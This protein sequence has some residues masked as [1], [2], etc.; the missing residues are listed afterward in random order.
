MIRLSLIAALGAAVASWLAWSAGGAVGG[1][2]L[3][4]YL[5][6][7]GL[8]GLGVLYQQHTLRTRPEFA[9]H[10]FTIAFFAKFVGMV[11][12]ALAFRYVPA[13]AARAD[14]RSFLVAFAV[15]ALLLL[16]SG[17]LDLLAL[18]KRSGR[19]LRSPRSL[20]PRS[21]EKGRTV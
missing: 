1:G 20:E 10:A 16:F 19:G 12:G 18:T 7:A 5:F 11:L 21:L 17:S 15:A 4:G 13:A 3:A 6:G 9:F 14:W 8:S 2:I